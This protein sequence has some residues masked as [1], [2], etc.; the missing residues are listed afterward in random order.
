MKPKK[1]ARQIPSECRK[2][3]KGYCA[4]RWKHEMEVH[5]NKSPLPHPEKQP[6]SNQI[7]EKL[8]TQFRRRE[9]RVK[10]WKNSNF[11]IHRLRI[12]VGKNKK[13]KNS[14]GRLRDEI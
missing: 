10:R 13:K 12:R 2:S 5:K 6:G 14:F 9:G 3:F 7:E 1:N 11:I 4:R 8:D